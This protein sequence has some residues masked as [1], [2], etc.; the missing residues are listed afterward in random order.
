MNNSDDM[1]NFQAANTETV[2]CSSH[3]VRPERSV[4]LAAAQPEE[5]IS[6]QS[7]I[8]MLV[9]PK[10]RRSCVFPWVSWIMYMFSSCASLA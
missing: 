9:P 1:P 5:S 8:A 3:S 2:P 10:G 7:A 4:A 6:L